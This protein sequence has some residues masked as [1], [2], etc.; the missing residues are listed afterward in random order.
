MSFTPIRGKSAPLFIDFIG[1]D[2]QYKIIGGDGHEYGP[3]SLD[4]LKEWVRDGRAAGITL[5]WRDDLARWAP[6]ASYSEL[7]ELFAPAPATPALEALIPVGFWTRTGALLIDQFLVS[8]LFSLVLAVI[9]VVFNLKVPQPDPSAVA[10]NFQEFSQII[11]TYLAQMRPILWWYLPVSILLRLVYEAGFTG[12]L[13]ATPGKLIFGAQVVRTDGS[14]IGY[15]QAALRW[16]AAQVNNFCL[17][18]IG[19]LFVAVRADKRAFHDLLAG[20]RVVYKR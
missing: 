5:T 6:A 19:Y 10:S 7:A 17:L 4:E 2:E 15:G 20:T 8:L 1:M 12:R 14:R 16:F 11:D 18:G 13:G 9:A 3:A